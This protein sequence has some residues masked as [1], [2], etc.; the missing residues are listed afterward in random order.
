MVYSKDQ[1]TKKI[2]GDDHKTHSIKNETQKFGEKKALNL[3]GLKKIL[4][5]NF[6]F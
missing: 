6:N 3:L 4:T 2:I 1:F 5:M